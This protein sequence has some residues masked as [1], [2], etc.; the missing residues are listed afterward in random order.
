MPREYHKKLSDEDHDYLVLLYNCGTSP[1]ALG[2]EFS[3]NP[4][5]IRKTTNA[6]KESG[7]YILKEASEKLRYAVEAFSYCINNESRLNDRDRG[8]MRILKE[9]IE[10]NILN[11]ASSFTLNDL[12]KKQDP[13]ERL[14][15]IIFGES[16]YV[17]YDKER[18]MIS[19]LS[20]AI[21]G[22]SINLSSKE[23]MDSIIQYLKS[24][25][26]KRIKLGEYC[27][28]PLSDAGKNEF[29][30]VLKTLTPRE[31][32]VICLRY[33]F[34]EPGESRTLEE[35]GNLFD[36]TGENIR[37][38][39]NQAL[40][41][42]KHVSRSKILKKYLMSERIEGITTQTEIIKNLYTELDKKDEKIRNL[43]MRLIEA[44]MK[45]PKG[46]EELTEMSL[47][48]DKD[49]QHLVNQLSYSVDDLELSVRAANVLRNAK[50]KY[51][52]ELVQKTD[53]ELLHKR[54]FGR[55]SLNEIKEVLSGMNL[56]L[57]MKGIEE[58]YLIN[59]KITSVPN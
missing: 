58:E 45:C 52:G 36:V 50:I 44:Q 21:K 47:G 57:G 14:L 39:E 51:L 35:V 41:K 26:I 38:I 28:I 27:F 15:Y 42:L 17:D 43:E 46:I 29:K 18:R 55:K 11:K 24:E 19:D 40:R 23:T 32:K 34:D 7:E 37:R 30:N 22:P 53:E 59:G 2:K 56:H 5:L 1:E 16:A 13:Y 25:Y 9:S 31:E 33:G 10:L 4:S 49:T 8:A 6:A 12:M 20:E 54:N 3:V 48:L